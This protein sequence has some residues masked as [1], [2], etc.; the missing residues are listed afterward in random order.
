MA[1]GC[2]SKKGNLSKEVHNLLAELV[3]SEKV[4]KDKET[5]KYSLS[6]TQA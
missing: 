2:K 3:K 6:K 5:K 4:D 1:N